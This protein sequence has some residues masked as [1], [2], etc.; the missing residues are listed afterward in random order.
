MTA[1]SF[2]VIVMNTIGE[3]AQ[4]TRVVHSPPIKLNNK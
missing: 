2:N 3:W 1:H 4:Q